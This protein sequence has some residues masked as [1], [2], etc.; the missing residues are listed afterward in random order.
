MLLERGADPN[1]FYAG[2]DETIHYS[3]LASV[4][5]RGEE[6]APTHPRARELA[7]LLLDHG[8]EPYDVQV[9]YNGFAGHA[10]H[11]RLA[12]DDLVWLLELIYQ[13]SVNRG[14]QDDWRDPEWR[15]LGMG[16]YGGGAWYLLHNALKGNYIS[17]ARWV[18][19][20]G[21]SPN[22]PAA[23]DPRTPAGPL[24]EQAR[25][26]GLH[27]FAELLASYGA[28]RTGAGR[29]DQEDSVLR[30]FTAA[31]Y[32]DVDTVR[33]LLDSGLS[34]D[35]ANRNRARP[36]HVAAY[37]G[38][39]RVARLLI[40][41]GAEIDPR[42][43]QHGTS[44]IYWALYGQRW[45]TVDLV[46]PYSRDVWALVPA[47]KAERLEAVLAEQPRLARASW[48]GGTPLFDLP[49]D[50]PA[51]ERIVR[52]FLAHG[53]DPGFTRNDGAT[54]ER[55]ARARGLSGAADLL[56]RAVNAE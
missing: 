56:R 38:S 49:D 23:S 32:D 16:G 21:A 35:A 7:A 33:Q 15:M 29:A 1:V 55:I 6:Q 46:A 41:R 11:P 44:P 20:H 54:A 39:V 4:I 36:L 27:D 18:L 43:D 26:A 28:P 47:G 42:D 19:E 50:E 40:E 25:R 34:P 14:R 10:S 22:P 3:A 48:E 13:A 9:L 37:A 2:G 30:L 45:L 31:E 51:A 17:I 5:G 12:D 52:L 53:A 8:A 24:Y